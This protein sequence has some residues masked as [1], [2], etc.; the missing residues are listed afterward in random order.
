[1]VRSVMSSSHNLHIGL[2]FVAWY[3]ISSASS[4]LSKITLQNYPYPMT[5]ALASLCCVDLCSTPL[6]RI[7]RVKQSIISKYHL[8]YYIIPI[9]IGKV[10]AVVSAYIS[11]GKVSVSYVQTIKATMPLFAVVSAR[12]VLKERQSKRVYL[13][14]IPIVI[15]VTIAT[16]TE[17]SFDLGGLLSALLSTGIYS[18]LNVFVK[19]VLEG[20]DIHPLYLL[21]LNSR[22][23]AILLFPIWCLHDGLIL[24]HGAE[25]SINEKSPHEINFITYLLCSGLLSFLQNLCAFTLINHLSPLSYAVAS[26]A[27]RTTVISASLFT[28]RNPVTLTNAFGMLLSIFGVLIY[29]QVRSLI[30][31]F[32]NF[33][34][35]FHTPRC[36][37]P[38]T[39]NDLTIFVD[40]K[41]PVNGRFMSN[42]SHK[43]DLFKIERFHMASY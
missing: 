42:G 36:D 6:L 1:M 22:I 27:K 20:T 26:A 7:W 29:N 31:F 35:E 11:V 34:E 40:S 21:A 18:V 24:W 13:S 16:V 38:G 14:L 43:P 3:F 12:I 19:K 5:I 28:L 4:V 37:L 32:N 2:I 33:C 41:T 10:I 9:S 23:A 17:I 15:G 30:T 39:C 25:M 8:T